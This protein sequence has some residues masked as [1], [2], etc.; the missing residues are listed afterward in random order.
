MDMCRQCFD[1]EGCGLDGLLK[2]V[3]VVV[4][5]AVAMSCEADTQQVDVQV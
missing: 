4:L 1:D 5:L 2:T 3:G